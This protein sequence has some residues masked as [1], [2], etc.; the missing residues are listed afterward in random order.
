MCHCI[1]LPGSVADMREPKR[2]EKMM[3]QLNLAGMG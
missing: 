3:V 2:R 1:F